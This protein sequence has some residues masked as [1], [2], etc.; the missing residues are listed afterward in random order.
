[1]NSNSK[2]QQS[3]FRLRSLRLSTVILS[4]R[5]V[6]TW[7][8]FVCRHR[9]ESA[10]FF[11]WICILERWIL[12]LFTFHVNWGG[13]RCRKSFTVFCF[14]HVLFAAI[15][16]FGKHCTI[17]LKLIIYSRPEDESLL[18]FLKVWKKTLIYIGWTQA[19]HTLARDENNR[20][21]RSP[22][23]RL[24]F[25]IDSSLDAFSLTCVLYSDKLLLCG[26]NAPKMICRWTGAEQRWQ[27]RL[28][29]WSRKVS[30]YI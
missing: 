23:K 7:N 16:Q 30:K 28:G 27:H 10:Y 18:S 1:M 15:L 6:C 22:H 26:N 17:L 3:C 29:S 14:W 9:P 5:R 4:K 13:C 8:C 12:G 21:P 19:Q 25:V 2:F 24:R 20:F 11:L